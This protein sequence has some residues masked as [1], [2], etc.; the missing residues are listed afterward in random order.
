MQTDVPS[1]SSWWRLLIV[2]CMVILNSL[3][4]KMSPNMAL[5]DKTVLFRCNQSLKRLPSKWQGK[6]S[7][8]AF[9]SFAAAARSIQR[10]QHFLRAILVHT[11]FPSFHIPPLRL[12]SRW[13][14]SPI[15]LLCHSNRLG[16][17]VV[18]SL[19]INV[20]H[21]M[22]TSWWLLKSPLF[23]N[24]Q[25]SHLLRLWGDPGHRVARSHDF[26]R[27]LSLMLHSR[28]FSLDLAQ[29]TRSRDL[30]LVACSR[31]LSHDISFHTTTLMGDQ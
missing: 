17:G 31:H 15:R 8:T 21:C 29:A 27:N 26:S 19:S 30:S 25:V 12:L 28:D 9:K 1:H 6:D 18:H 24:T 3:Y 14:I 4:A 2:P 16:E 10:Y 11:Y 13:L 7:G 23:L 5:W 22:Y 20:C